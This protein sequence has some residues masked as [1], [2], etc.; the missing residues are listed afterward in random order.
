MF[1]F[2]KKN[3]NSPIDFMVVGLGNPGK[4]YQSTRHNCGYISIDYIADKLNA[5]VNK[6]KF[7]SLIGEAKINGKRVLLLKPTTFMN[8]SGQAVKE[9]MNFYKLDPEKVLL[10]FDD[11]S[12]NVGNIR[13]KRK[14]SD[15]GQKGVQNIIYL[16]SNDNFPRI[17]VGIGPKPHP[18]YDLKDFVLSKF[19][20]SEAKDLEKLLPNIMDAVSLIVDGE[21][22]KAMNLYN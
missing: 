4:E 11:V 18:D 17:K 21:I 10:I 1:G 15:G 7:K 2:R 6:I 8:N 5:K 13:V 3:A 22:D 16:C 12:L 9:A 20:Q 19:S 14:G